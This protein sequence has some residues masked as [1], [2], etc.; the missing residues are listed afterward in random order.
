MTHVTCRLTAKYRDQVRNLTLECGRPFYIGLRLVFETLVSAKD[1]VIRCIGMMYATASNATLLTLAPPPGPLRSS[2]GVRIISTQRTV[3][4]HAPAATCI[5]NVATYYAA[6]MR[7]L[8]NSVIL[9]R[10]RGISLISSYSFFFMGRVM[11][12]QG[13][14]CLRG[15][16]PQAGALLRGTYV[17]HSLR[18][19]LVQTWRPASSVDRTEVP[20]LYYYCYTRSTAS[21]PGQPG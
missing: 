6:V 7:C 19:G 3:E 21:F 9:G 18:S 17:W 13:T 16:Y 4:V 1:K 15:P 8:K 5:V 20:T 14:M 11:R 10:N 2:R 12:A